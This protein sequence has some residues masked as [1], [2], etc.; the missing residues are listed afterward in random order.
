MNTVEQSLTTYAYSDKLRLGNK[1]ETVIWGQTVGDGGYVIANIKGYDCYIS[2]GVNDE[3]SFTRDFLPWSGL[4]CEHAYAFDGTI[5]GYPYKYTRNIHFVGKNIDTVESEKYTD[6]RYLIH[7]YNNIF[8]KMD[9]EGGEW[10]WLAQLRREELQH[11]KQIAIE[12]HSPC[13]DDF[14]A[15][16]AMKQA[17]LAALAADFFL[18]HAHANNNGPG[19]G[20]DRV[21]HG[22]PTILELTYVRRDAA[23]NAGAP[24]PLNTSPFP[25][26]GLDVKNAPYDD[27]ALTEPPFC[28]STSA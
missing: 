1:G 8:L 2:A 5:V 11:F 26:A 18:V 14:G 10:R 3:E 28:F 27:M 23:A 25:I 9:I 15:E 20:K 12:I 16:A 13:D 22:L 7:K 6:L 19:W 24:L 21:R 4:S 17:V